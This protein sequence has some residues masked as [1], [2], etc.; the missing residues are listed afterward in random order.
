MAGIGVAVVSIYITS[1]CEFVLL[2]YI[3]NWGAE[4]VVVWYIIP[5]RVLLV[6]WTDA[7]CC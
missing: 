2:V 6:D 5:A 7:W 3:G 1:E 4:M